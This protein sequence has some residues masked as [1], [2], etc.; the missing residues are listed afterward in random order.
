MFDYLAY[1]NKIPVNKVQ[2]ETMPK[3]NPLS[4]EYKRFWKEQKRSCIEGKWVEQDGIHKW[5]PGTLHFY[6]NMWSILLNEKKTKS[7]TKS[8]GR[9]FV[10]DLEWIKNYV[11]AAARGFSGFSSDEEYTCH[12]IME[13]DPINLAVQIQFLKPHIKETLYDSNGN[14]KKYKKALE[15]LYED[16]DRPMGKPLYWNM[17]LN[18][19][20]IESRGTGK[21]YTMSAFCGHNF[22][23]DGAMDYDEYLE[24]REL[25]KPLSSETLIGAIDSKYSNDL[26][27]K[28]KLGLENLPGGMEIGHI[29]YP[30]PLSKSH[31][32]SW[33]SGK[34]VIQQYQ[35]KLGGKWEWFG[36]KSKFQ[37]RSFKDN[38]FAA[39]GTRPGFSVLEEVGFMYNLEPTLGQ[40]AECTADG[41][42]KFGTIWMTGTG[43]DMEGGATE[44]VKKVFYDVKANKCLEF[45]DIFEKSPHK[46]GFFIPAYMGLNQFKDELGNTDRARA[47]AFLKLEREDKAKAKSKKPLNDE[48]QQRPLVP[49]EAFLITGGNIFDSPELTEW[50]GK[51]ETM[52]DGDKTGRYGELYLDETGAT[53]FKQNFDGRLKPTD[54]PMQPAEDLNGCVVI[55]EEPVDNPPYSFYIAGLD[56][57]AHDEAPNSVSLG[58]IQIFKRTMVG[59]SSFD[60]QVAEYTGRPNSAAEFYETCRKLLIYY[61]A[62]CLYEN[63][64]NQFKTFLQNKNSLHLLAF[65]PTVL[66]NNKADTIARNYGL[67]MTNGN[68]SS[69]GIKDELEIYLRDWLLEEAGDGALNLHHIYSVPLLKELKNYNDKGNFDR[70][71]AMMLVIAQKKQLHYVVSKRKD[72]IKK[73]EW[74]TRQYH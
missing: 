20:D 7:K 63:N 29:K 10:R 22:L 74:A 26:I 43:G 50:L 31:T 18:V 57:Y 45:D 19:V 32:G 5:V 12:R 21:S 28:I 30:S 52:A 13:L 58:S 35:K 16:K 42:D 1:T 46:I 54:Y 61:N 15:Y 71:I 36:T 70:A 37:H 11:Y 62:L 47:L 40:M 55:W 25:G 48:L 68:G 69:G 4:I 6:V 60:M 14:L 51:L 56:P 17:A 41:A 3:I 72:E 23:F 34:A 73:S 33:E 24:K 66:K 64:Y 49:S 9:P 53:V 2:M 39:N 65:E 44:A 27:S 38:P 8:I 59:G 67:R